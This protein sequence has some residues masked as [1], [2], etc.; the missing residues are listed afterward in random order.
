MLPE[1]VRSGDFVLVQKEDDEY[2]NKYGEIVER[3]DTKV[4][5]MI[6]GRITIYSPDELHLAARSGRKLHEEIKEQID[7]RKT[8]HLTVEDINE[9]I[10]MAIDMEDWEWATALV[11]RKQIMLTKG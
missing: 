9:L 4:K 8:D 10:N 11:N 6:N 1:N 5:I 3:T 2:F 7:A